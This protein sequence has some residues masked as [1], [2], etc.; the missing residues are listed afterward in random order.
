MNE[1]GL[2]INMKERFLT[3]YLFSSVLVLLLGLALQMTLGFVVD[4]HNIVVNSNSD[5]ANSMVFLGVYSCIWYIVILLLNLRSIVKDKH[6]KNG[7]ITLEEA[8]KSH[9]LVHKAAVS[10]F[11]TLLVIIG[12]TIV[13]KIL[14]IL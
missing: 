1:N 14:G 11:V 7:K 10:G 12:A 6:V 13:L 4:Y 5:I 8:D 2:P 9:M 3:S